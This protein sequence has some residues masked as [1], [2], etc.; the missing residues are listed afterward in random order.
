M[1]KSNIYRGDS[2]E[3]KYESQPGSWDAYNDF[4]LKGS[5]LRF[6]K[7]LSRYELFKHIIDK[8]GDIVEGGVLKGAGVLYWAKLI[9]IFNPLSERRVIG[10]DTFE[11]YPE[12]TRHDYEVDIAEDFLVDASYSPVSPEEIMEIAET[13]A[14][15]HRVELVK[16]D[17]THTIEEYARENPGLRVAL[18]N[19]DLDGFSATAS[20]LEYLYPKLVAGGVV[21]FDE[22]GERQW[23]ESQAVDEFFKD[24]SVTIQ[25]LP[26]S[27]SPTAYVV[28]EG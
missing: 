9:Q 12:E 15:A 17:A 24:K 13:N 18:I 7:V 28:K 4:M 19:C 8:P 16:G 26:W 20:A 6:T 10:F 11:G 14:L 25:S 27:F 5:L 23:G 2:L 3:P 22:Y 21:A 1:Q